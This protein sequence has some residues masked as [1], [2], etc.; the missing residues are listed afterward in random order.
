MGLELT[1]DDG[2][3]QIGSV[4][5]FWQK[6]VLVNSGKGWLNF[7]RFG[8]PDCDCSLHTKHFDNFEKIVFLETFSTIIRIYKGLHLA[9]FLGF[10]FEVWFSPVVQPTCS[11]TGQQRKAKRFQQLQRSVDP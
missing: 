4:E 10:D 11:E 9:F 2:S 6:L 3:G 5:L 1:D 8:G 7:E